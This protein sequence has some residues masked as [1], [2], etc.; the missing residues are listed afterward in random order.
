M[1]AGLDIKPLL[2]GEHPVPDIAAATKG[3]LK[4]LSLRR[5]R[6]EPGL[7][8]GVADL[9]PVF[10]RCFGFPRHPLPTPSIQA[11]KKFGRGCIQPR[12]KKFF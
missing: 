2:V 3:L 10:T 12:P 6:I 11:V 8:G 1:D 5:V 7:D 9:L 4:K